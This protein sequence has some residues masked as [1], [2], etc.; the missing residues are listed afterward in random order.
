MATGVGL[1]NVWLS[2]LSRPTSKPPN[3]CKYLSYI[4]YVRR[5][6]ANFV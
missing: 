5:V 6:I 4:S 3:G 1:S 2:P